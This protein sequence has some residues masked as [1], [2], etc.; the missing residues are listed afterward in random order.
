MEAATHEASDTSQLPIIS[1]SNRTEWSMIPGV[2]VRVI[3]ARGRFE[4][5]SRII[6]LNCTARSPITN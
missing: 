4:I 1:N 2:I 3:C 5:T 6:L